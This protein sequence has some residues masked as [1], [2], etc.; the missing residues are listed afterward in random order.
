MPNTKTTNQQKQSLFERLMGSMARTGSGKST[1][2]PHSQ[3]QTQLNDGE[4]H[5]ATFGSKTAIDTPSGGST[6]AG[7]RR[8][9][10]TGSIT[11]TA[12]GRSTGYVR[13][14]CFFSALDVD[15]IVGRRRYCHALPLVLTCGI[16]F[17]FPLF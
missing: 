9:I 10:R 3:S 8:E 5:D 14:L 11:G 16:L 4:E 13:F 7:S 1:S 15:G 12:L 2:A 17:L 6:N